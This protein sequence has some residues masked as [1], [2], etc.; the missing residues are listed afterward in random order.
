MKIRCL[1][2][3]RINLP[4]PEEIREIFVQGV[5]NIRKKEKEV[6]KYTKEQFEQNY[7][8]IK[9]IVNQIVMGKEERK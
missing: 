6:E 8:E 9:R 1:F 4:N 3:L 2:V 7:L 5:R